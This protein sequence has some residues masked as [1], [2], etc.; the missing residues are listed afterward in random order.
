MESHGPREGALV[1]T[2]EGVRLIE[3]VA[4]G[5]RDGVADG[6]LEGVVLG[7]ADGSREGVAVGVVGTR[8]GEAVGVVVGVLLRVG[9]ALGT[10]TTRA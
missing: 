1:G 8:D 7:T 6:G 5:E 10:A 3:G 2:F 9:V 4:V